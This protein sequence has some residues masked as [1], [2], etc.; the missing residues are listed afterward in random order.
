MGGRKEVMMKRKVIGFVLAA[1]MVFS[2]AACGG[3]AGGESTAGKE[4]EDEVIDTAPEQKDEGQEETDGGQQDGWPE[5]NILPIADGDVELVIYTYIP[6][7]AQQVYKD[8]SECPMVKKMEEET[9][10]KFS[11]VHPPQGDDGTFFNTL[12]AS[13]EYPD[14]F[15]SNFVSY[16]GGPA[17]AMEDGILLN[18]NEL[19]EQYGYNYNHFL[20]Q[21]SE[22]KR[23]LI[24]KKSVTDDG[25]LIRLGTII[26]PDYLEGRVHSGIAIRKDLLEKYNLDMPVT[27]AEYEAFFDAC[28]SDGIRTPLALAKITDNQWKTQ[29]YFAS[30]FGVTQTG[31]FLDENGRATY[32]R[33]QPGYKEYLELLNSWYQKG[34]ITSDFINM[35]QPDAQKMFQAGEAGMT[36]CGNWQ[37]ETLNTVGK[38][39][40]PDFYAVGCPYPRKS[41]EDK[42]GFATQ[43]ESVNDRAVFISATCEHPVEAIKF[44]DYL[45]ADDTQILTAWGIG[46]D[47]EPGYVEDDQGNKTFADFIANSPDYD[48]NVGRMRYAPNCFQ[49][50]WDEEMEKQQYE[51]YPSKLESWEN[52]GYNTDNT[53]LVPLMI[54]PSVEESAEL[55]KIMTEIDTYTDEMVM[56]FIV[57]SE[58][59]D[60]FDEFVETVKSMNIDRALEIEQAAVDR[61]NER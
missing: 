11:F 18:M 41:G 4:N 59:L 8:L 15:W 6:E 58:P 28:L 27:I 37:I 52:W 29:N 33:M 31:F 17:A 3:T 1:A 39:A 57:G 61:Y 32:S 35:S 50:M 48:M 24:A 26:Q 46:P 30:A 20:E 40:E 22:E 19:V 2:L 47:G 16:P 34:Y 5:E 13:G 9:G 42:L 45:Y 12:I 51:P 10:L 7:G 21:F 55:S 25:T 54:S 60:N 36:V 43:M 49:I 53:G 23:E 44:I 38:E 14:I 56:K